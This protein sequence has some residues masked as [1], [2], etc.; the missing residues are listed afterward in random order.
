[1]EIDGMDLFE[2]ENIKK[3]LIIREKCKGLNLPICI[4]SNNLSAILPD[5]T[6]ALMMLLTTSVTLALVER[7]SSTRNLFTKLCTFDQ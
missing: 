4:V 7:S 5:M 2:S 1:M 6:I 3:I